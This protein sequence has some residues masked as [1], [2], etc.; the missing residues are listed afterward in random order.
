M[1][2]GWSGSAYPRRTLLSSSDRAIAKALVEHRGPIPG[3]R[4]CRRAQRYTHPLRAAFRCW[5]AGA[6][7][8]RQFSVDAESNGGTSMQ[9]LAR[10]VTR[11]EA[12]VRFSED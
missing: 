6:R 3:E 4:L 9:W 2:R 5:H 12:Q 11:S 8:Q 10:A 1:G 7:H